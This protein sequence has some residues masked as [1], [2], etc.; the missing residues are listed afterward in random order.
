MYSLIN[1]EI[2]Q[3]SVETFDLYLNNVC[4]DISCEQL[5][6]NN[7]KDR[8][9]NTISFSELKDHVEC[10]YRHKLKYVDKVNMFEENVNTN[11]GTAL[12][13]ACET[14][15]KTRE[16]KYELALDYIVQAWEKHNLPDLG[17]WLKEA[18]AL[19]EAVPEFLDERFPGWECFSAEEDLLEK[20]EGEHSLDFTFKGFIDGVIKCNDQYTI[21]DWKTSG[22][23]WNKYKKE[24]ENL[25]MQL[26]LYAKFWGQKHNIPLSKI[27]VGFVVLNRDLENPERIEFFSFPIEESG[28]KKTLNILNNSLNMSKKGMYFKPWKYKISYQQGSCRFCDYNETPHC[29]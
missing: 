11:F 12:H 13:E 9:I 18:N 5:L 27:R 15:L 4:K 2:D 21:I 3:C 22:K 1:C 29:P 28:V 17:N 20:I 14:Y 19:L 7:G 6:Y 26:V 16:M 10:S 8:C 24:D 23:G 25:K